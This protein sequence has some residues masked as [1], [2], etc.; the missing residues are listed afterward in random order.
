MSRE[1]DII[2]LCNQI[3][4]DYEVVACGEGVH[5]CECRYCLGT[6]GYEGEK[7]EVEHISYCIVLKAKD[8]LTG[9]DK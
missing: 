8:I 9:S 3:V 7:G 2:C 5:E 6:D 1:Q 4:R